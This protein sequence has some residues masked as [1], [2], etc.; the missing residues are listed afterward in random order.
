MLP[1]DQILSQSRLEAHAMCTD[2]T[3]KALW[4]ENTTVFPSK[5]ELTSSL[6]T[7]SSTCG[8]L[9]DT[10]YNFPN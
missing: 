1:R 3:V 2:A 6:V 5:F 7:Y 10:D 4:P 8:D 9:P